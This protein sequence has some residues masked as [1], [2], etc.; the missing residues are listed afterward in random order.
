MVTALPTLLN[1]HGVASV[2]HM[3]SRTVARHA[4][5][6]VAVPSTVHNPANYKI[7]YI[8][9]NMKFKSVDEFVI[10]INN[11]VY[12]KLLEEPSYET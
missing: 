2:S 8:L 7:K 11:I 1:P 6:I 9:F 5:M 3:Y 12:Y 4:N 10:V